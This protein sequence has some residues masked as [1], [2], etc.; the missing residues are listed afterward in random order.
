MGRRQ[1]L[2]IMAGLSMS[3]VMAGVQSSIVATAR[4]SIVKDLGRFD[5]TTWIFVVFLLAQ[6]ISTN[7]WGKLSDLIGRQRP[8]QASITLFLIGSAICGFAP[9]MAILIIGRAVQGTGAGGL[10]TLT[11]SIMGDL[12]S[13]RERG[14]YLGYMTTAYGA[15]TIVGPLIGGLVV[16]YASWRWIFFMMMP[17]GFGALAISRVSLNLPFSRREHRIDYLGMALLAIW[18]TALVLACQFGRVDGWTSPKILALVF[19]ALAG[20]AI[21]V[22]WEAR[23]PEPLLPLHLFK[24]RVFL[25]STLIGFLLGG[26]LISVTIMTPVYLQ[27]VSGVSAAASGLLVTPTTLGMLFMGTFTG[28]R[29]AVHG[30][31]RHFPI[32][33]SGIAVVGMGLLATLSVSSG[34]VLPAV[35]LL[36]FGIGF[37]STNQVLSVA[38][39]NIVPHKDLGIATSANSFFRALGQTIGSAVFSVVLVSRLDM[40]L[41]RLVP[42][43]RI[44]AASIQQSPKQLL[45]LEPEVR[46]GIVQSFAN[47]L[48]V[49]FLAGIP[50][51]A[52]AFLL[53]WLV[54]EHPL[55]TT[56]VIGSK[57]TEPQDQL[58]GS[59]A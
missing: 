56:A 9:N 28:R 44:N 58:A 6:T 33:G 30:K 3:N 40:W 59:T 23:A 50:A 45:A 18:V 19:T 47:S 1:I 51:I 22:A 12:M 34:W 54:P 57:L 46:D 52:I 17:F 43:E 41:E 49:V 7:V 53:T 16:D 2:T 42:G 39:Q 24:E 35:Y 48:H 26:T 55:R 20:G 5:L 31:Y 38:I 25:V 4:P 36:V 15:A 29:I 14:K 32:V 10:F 8:Y 11:M 27:I 37:G 21:F 13:P